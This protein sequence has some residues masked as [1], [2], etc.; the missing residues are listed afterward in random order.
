VTTGTLKKCVLIVEDE[1]TIRELLDD[2]LTSEGFETRVAS[3]GRSALEI[4]ERDRPD[5]ILMDVMLPVLDGATATRLLKERDATRDIRVVAM[6]ANSAALDDR[7]VLPA[8]GVIRKPFDLEKL[9][10]QILQ[11]LAMPVRVLSV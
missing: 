2:F 8:D 11:Q 10:A 6:S 5:L 1:P 9:L 4:A 3:D 7:R